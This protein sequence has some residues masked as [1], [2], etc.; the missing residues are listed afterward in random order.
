MTVAERIAELAAALAEMR[1]A[2]LDGATVDLAGLDGAIE[3]ALGAA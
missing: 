1:A 3:D 2:V